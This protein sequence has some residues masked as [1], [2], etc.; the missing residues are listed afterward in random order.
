MDDASFINKFHESAVKVSDLDEPDRVRATAIEGMFTFFVDQLRNHPSADD[1]REMAACA[2]EVIE[3][4]HVMTAIHSD[5]PRLA[6]A[7]VGYGALRVS[8][9]FIP[10]GWPEMVAADLFGQLGGVTFVLSQAVDAYN[11]MPIEGILSRARAYEGA[12]LRTLDIAS[13]SDWQVKALRSPPPASFAYERRVV[14]P[15]S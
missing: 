13:P 5:M 3:H 15:P 10:V 7:I 6:M 2:W 8:Y 4:G 1:V 11:E 12:M 14:V 9:I